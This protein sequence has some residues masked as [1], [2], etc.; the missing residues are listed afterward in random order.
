MKRIRKGKDISVRWP[1]LTNGEPESLDGRDLTLF[2]KSQYNVAKQVEFTTEDN[3]VLFTFYGTEQQ[4]LGGYQ[5]TLWENYCKQGQ[6]AV[7][8]CDAFELVSCTCKEGGEDS[9]LTTETVDLDASSIEVGIG[10]GGSAPVNIVQETGDSKTAVMSQDAVSR[11]ITQESEL[12]SKADANLD[13][14]IDQ[15]VGNIN[16]LLES[17]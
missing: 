13:N 6:T 11:A 4:M 5:L 8:C 17:I 10:G 14:K 16:A 2:V 9:G 3:I 1:I 7:D 15:T 12:R